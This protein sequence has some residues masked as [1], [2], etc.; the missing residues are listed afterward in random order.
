M[1]PISQTR[2]DELDVVTHASAN[3]SL[4]VALQ[5]AHVFDWRPA[6][7]A[8]PV[9]FLSPRSL[10][11][12]GKAIR[13][14]VPVCFPWFGPKAGDPA[15]PQHGF[16][17]T[18]AWQLVAAEATGEGTARV[19]LDFSDDATTRTAWP[20]A[21]AARLEIHA[22]ARL[23]LALT[24]RNTGADRFTFG[25]ALHT[26]LAVS[27]VRAIRLRGLEGA[28]VLD[29]VG[30][31]MIER[32]EGGDPISFSGETDR[33]YLDTAASCTIDDP[34]WNRRIHVSKT[35][36]RSTVVWNPWT[37]KA[38]AL[39]DLGEDAWPG[40]LC[41]ETCNAADDVVTLA[42][43]ASHTLGAEIQVEPR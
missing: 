18:S 35:G 9:L 40:F 5:G 39:A 32:R 34:G 4:E 6:G 22:G 29:K 31:H 14:G 28:R 38:R 3:G 1:S 15:A 17:R 27:D 16:A 41:V 26:Y 42:P 19:A 25:A 24:V 33:V 13:G 11:R 30:G 21:F 20:H 12:R 36:S 43:G 8:H 37:E 7:S 2:R 23:A 10:F